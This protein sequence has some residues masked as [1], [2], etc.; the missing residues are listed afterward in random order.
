MVWRE[1]TNHLD[2]CYFCL[3]NVKGFNKKNKQYLQYPNIP[4]AIL[5]VAHSEEIPVPAF[6]ELP[7]IY[8][9]YLSSPGTTDEDDAT[10]LFQ[11][12]DE[13]CEKIIFVHS[14]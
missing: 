11:P 8:D 13:D 5:P 4:S 10:D 1:P 6:T 14:V 2:D 9:T 12:S 7:K 3:V